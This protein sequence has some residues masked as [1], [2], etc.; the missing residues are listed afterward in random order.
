VAGFR[1]RSRFLGLIA[2]ALQIP[3]LRADPVVTVAV[4]VIVPVAMLALGLWFGHDGHD[5]E[6][7][8]AQYDRKNKSGLSK[9]HQ[10]VSTVSPGTGPELKSGGVT[11]LVA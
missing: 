4:A 3:T 6:A 11:K 9:R 5:L 1:Q 7:R 2:G 8:D 10:T